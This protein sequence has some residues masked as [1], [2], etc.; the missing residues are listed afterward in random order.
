MALR[1]ARRSTGRG[2]G[3][4][5]GIAGE[6]AADCVEALDWF[7]AGQTTKAVATALRTG[8]ASIAAGLRRH[9]RDITPPAHKPGHHVIKT[10]TPRKL[11]SPAP[12]P[13]RTV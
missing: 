8:R 10:D 11:R 2:D 1:D 5:P 4:R 13:P 12:G 6:G 3:W 9:A 7:E